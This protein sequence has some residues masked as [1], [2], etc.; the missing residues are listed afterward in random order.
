MS[1]QFSL[2]D[3][4]PLSSI[5]GFPD[6][7]NGIRI[8]GATAR[9]VIDSFGHIVM[10]EFETRQMSFSQ[11]LVHWKKPVRIKCEYTHLTPVL[12]CRAMNNNSMCELIKGAGEIYLKKNQLC[13]LT[14]RKWSGLIISEKPG[15]HHFTHLTW[16]IDA[17]NRILRNDPYYAKISQ[18]FQYALPER[19]S[20]THQESSDQLTGVLDKLIATN[21]E[22][23]Q[24]RIQF[25][26]LMSRYL[27][28][29][30]QDLKE[31]ESVKKKMRESDWFNINKA[32]KIIDYNLNT[33]F[34]TS[35]LSVKIGVNEY[36]LK[37]LFPKV[38]GY[39]VEEYR[40]Y[41][42]L[43]KTAK[44]IVQNPDLAIKMFSDESGYTSLATFTRAFSRMGCTPGELRGDTWDV[45]KFENYIV[46]QR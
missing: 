11:M 8:A 40:K 45:T 16:N 20:T 13:A 15:E 27:K 22:E 14:G 4:T 39:P 18:N 44:R 5:P 23:S 29:V 26:E 31:G 3:G 28:L 32:K 19:L 30:F 21:F 1:L 36:K 46:S 12:F 17:I 7:Y 9:H 34:T 42:L 35:E 24:G 33:Q 43:V 41:R 10:Q 25:D 38:A 2:T 37:K 6:N